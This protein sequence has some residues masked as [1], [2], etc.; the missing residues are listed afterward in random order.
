MLNAVR[1]DQ[2]PIGQIDKEGRTGREGK[3]REGKGREAWRIKDVE[4]EGWMEWNGMDG[5]MDGFW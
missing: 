5:W 1:I 4:S 3:G 2:Q